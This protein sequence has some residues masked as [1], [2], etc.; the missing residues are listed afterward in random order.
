[1]FIPLAFLVYSYTGNIIII[2]G[3]T[4]TVMDSCCVRK[5]K[6]RHRPDSRSHLFDK[7]S[8]DWAEIMESGTLDDPSHYTATTAIARRPPRMV[9][10][11]TKFVFNVDEELAQKCS[12]EAETQFMN[13]DNM[14]AITVLKATL[15]LW[16]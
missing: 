7:K 1:M 5:V 16:N 14:A 15:R 3:I 6:E 4:N 9:A 12:T 13:S 10:F 11:K 8:H 2:R